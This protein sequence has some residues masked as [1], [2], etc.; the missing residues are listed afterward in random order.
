MAEKMNGFNFGMTMKKIFFA[1]IALAALVGCNT[2]V[3]EEVATTPQY[4][5]TSFEVDLNGES[6]AFNEKLEWSW[7]EGDQ[8][9]AY[10]V[11]GDKIVN[12]LSLKANGKFGTDE[13]TYV[14]EVTADFV[15]VYPATALKADKSLG[16]VQTGEWT[17]T[18]VGIVENATVNNIGTVEMNHM[19]AAFEIRVWDEGRQARKTIKAATITSESD[20]CDSTTATVE[21]LNTDTVVFN[22]AEGDF[23]FNLTLT[24]TDGATYTVAVPAKNFE[25]GKRTIL[26][27]E[28]KKTASYSVYTSYTDKNNSLDGHTIYVENVAVK[29]SDAKSVELYINGKKHS[30]LAVDGQLVSI[31]GLAVGEYNT[32]IKLTDGEYSY[33][34]KPVKVY[35]TGIPY[36]YKFYQSSDANVDAAGWTRNGKA[37]TKE[38]LMTLKEGGLAG[39]DSGWI[40]SPAYYAPADGIATN[41]TLEAKYYVAALS[42]SSYKAI[43]YVGATSSPK[44]SSSTASSLT[45]SGSNNTDSNKAWSTVSTGVNIPNGTQYVSINHNGATYKWGSR[46][47]LCSYKIEYRK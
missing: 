18:L 41:V 8:I 47:Y 10:Q 36:S 12:T 40:A 29:N 5:T 28:W 16:Y 11:A 26:N 23:A 24:A 20:F 35:V 3:M 7:I 38:D 39:S 34:S 43:L 13:F 17:P 45:L 31:S 30:N 25:N 32:Y 44:S 15:F 46:I 19:S 42:P 33:T 1:I 14:P 6:R 37:S 21:G 2:E 22:I 4:L 27:V 9:A